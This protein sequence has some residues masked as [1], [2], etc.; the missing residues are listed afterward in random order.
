MGQ[1]SD[2]DTRLLQVMM[3]RTRYD[4]IPHTD[5]LKSITERVLS[6][7]IPVCVQ[8]TIHIGTK[9]RNRL[10]NSSIV[11]RMGDRIA[12]PLHLK[13]LINTVPKEV[14]GLVNTDIYCEDRQNYRS[15]EKIM[16]P[17]VLQALEENVADS[18]G[19]VMYL[20]LCKHITSSYLQKDMKSIDR[21][22]S[23]WYA[24]FFLRIW[25]KVIVMQSKL[26]PKMENRCTLLLNFITNPA[27]ACIETNAQSLVELILKLRESKSPRMF[28][29]HFFSSQPCEEFFRRMRSMGT[30]NYTKINFT[31][32][33]LIHMVCRVELMHRIIFTNNQIVAPRMNIATELETEELVEERIDTVSGS[34]K[35][36]MSKDMPD[37]L[38]DFPSDELIVETIIK[39]RT[40]ALHKASKFG[41]N[42]SAN[43]IFTCDLKINPVV[44][45]PLPEPDP[46]PNQESDTD[47]ETDVEEIERAQENLV[48]HAMDEMDSSVASPGNINIEV[49]EE[50]GSSNPVRISNYVWSMTKSSDKVSADRLKRVQRNAQEDDSQPSKRLKLSEQSATSNNDN[51]N[52][53]KSDVLGIS[54]WAIFKNDIYKSST[55]DRTE[56]YLI[57]FVVGFRF[58]EEKLDEK[59]KKMKKKITSCKNEYVSTKKQT[60]NLASKKCIQALCIWYVW[61]ENKLLTLRKS[62]DNLVLNIGNYLATMRAPNMEKKDSNA[63]YVLSPELINELECFISSKKH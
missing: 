16:H 37:Q 19:T 56:S 18:E 50:D 49:I 47:T 35:L 9:M 58:L 24:V 28:L 52:L 8:D 1:S 4:L 46:E 34:G 38:L 48:E 11:L 55:G 57:G 44:P 15:L 6:N 27:Y 3:S 40:D 59:T 42:V 45:D 31:I 54:D 5:A 62:S 2:A 7:N 17:R 22:Y 39:A 25:R 43:D 23:L 21:I 41:M 14:H 13:V 20:R 51:C 36:N 53:F 61:D 33:D 12:T 63:F 60:G 26:K 29:T 30:A 32:Y 10:L